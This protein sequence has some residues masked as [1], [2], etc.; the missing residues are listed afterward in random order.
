MNRRKKIKKTENWLL[1][2]CLC[3]VCMGQVAANPPIRYFLMVKKGREVRKTGFGAGRSVTEL[4]GLCRSENYLP[5]TLCIK[6]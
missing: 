4:T 5:F 6:K 3:P 1:W 2:E